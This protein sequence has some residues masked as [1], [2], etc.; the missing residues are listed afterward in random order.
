MGAADASSAADASAG[1]ADTAVKTHHPESQVSASFIDLAIGGALRD[2]FQAAI[3]DTAEVIKLAVDMVENRLSPV[4]AAQGE[5][6]Q[7]QEVEDNI[8]SHEAEALAERISEEEHAKEANEKQKAGRSTRMAP[9]NKKKLTTSSSRG[10][11]SRLLASSRV[12]ASGSSKKYGPAFKLGDS[13]VSPLRKRVVVKYA[14]A[15]YVP[16]LP[17]ADRARAGDVMVAIE[18]C[19]DCEKHAWSLRHDAKRYLNAADRCLIAVVR[20]LLEKRLPVRVFAY[21]DVPSRNRLGALE[22]T[23]SVRNAA[24]ASKPWT[25]HTA[26]SKLDSS[27][28]PSA[29]RV[30]AKARTF[31]KWALK[32]GGITK[33]DEGPAA[34]ESLSGIL[35]EEEQAKEENGHGEDEQKMKGG[36]DDGEEDD[37]EVAKASSSVDQV[38]DW[39]SRSLSMERQFM[40][41]LMRLSSKASPSNSTAPPVLDLL[42]AG[43]AMSTPLETCRQRVAKLS[44]IHI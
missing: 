40:G 11:R 25:T 44:L 36:A 14:P 2:E 4:A 19:A 35:E 10:V 43:T 38:V 18:Q 5:G 34:P 21:K 9:S 7:E 33:P 15:Q 23:V 12:S 6:Q 16:F 31:V 26:F 1:A 3:T 37:G 20:G 29:K 30:A 22:V 24:E 27:S 13:V 28:W 39:E 17:H 32:E 8:L 41:W 42:G